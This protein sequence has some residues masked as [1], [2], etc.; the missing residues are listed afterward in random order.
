MR[1]L[2]YVPQPNTLV[3][4]TNRTVQGRYL[5]RPGPTFNDLFLGILGRTQGRHEMAIAAVSVLSNHMHLLLIVDDAQE[6]AGFMRDLK[7]KLA[8]EVNRLTGWRGTVFDRRYES[9]VVTDEDGAQIERLLYIL[10]N[11]VKE[12]LVERP[13]D[14]LGVHC[15]SALLTGESLTGHWF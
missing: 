3:S 4:I 14:W 11:G 15:V 9:A 8:R 5:L 2:R 13:Q 12:G 1:K 7:S 6:V 10:S